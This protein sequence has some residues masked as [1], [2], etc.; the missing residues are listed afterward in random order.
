MSANRWLRVEQIFNAALSH[1]P[2]ARR[3]ILDTECGTDAELKA[4]VESL[5]A[6]DADAGM[7]FNWSAV[8]EATALAK[9][10]P[11]RFAPGDRIGP[12]QLI[13]ALGA[14]GMGAVFLAHDT[15]L[16]RRVALKLIAPEQARDARRVDRFRTEA[17][18]AAALNHPNVA[19]VH[20]VGEWDN[21][22]GIAME[23][24]EGET[25]D[26]RLAHG[27]FPAAEIVDVAT[28]AAAALDEAH[29]H[30]VIHRDVKP[31]NVMIT[32][33][34]LVK[35]LDFG[36]AKMGRGLDSALEAGHAPALATATGLVMGTAA[37]TS[38]EQVLGRIVDGRADIFSLGATL[39]KLATG[40][41]PFDGRTPLETLHAVVHSEP[42][43]ISE[44]NPAVPTSLQRV[45]GKCLQKR[46]EDR[47]QSARELFV[48][49]AALRLAGPS[50]R[51]WNRRVPIRVSVSA[52]A[53]IAAA[54]IAAVLLIQRGSRQ[55]AIDSIAVLPFANAT[56]GADTEYLSD[57]ISDGLI[58]RLSQ[59][60]NI[61]VTARTSS[62]RYKGRAV[63][64]RA[65]ARALSVRGIVTGSV[66]SLGDELS[67]SVELVDG[68]NNRRLWTRTYTRRPTDLLAL[69]EDIAQD[70]SLQFPPGTIRGEA[71][72]LRKRPTS[73]AEAY[74]LYLKGRYLWNKRT[75]ETHLRA[76]SYFERA[77]A[78]DPRFALAYAG[79][80]DTY[81]LIS[82]RSDR[83]RFTA[84]R[85][86][87][88]KAITL[89]DTLAEAYAALGLTLCLYDWDWPG[90]GRAFERALQ[91]NP[92]YASAHQW[93]GMYYQIAIGRFDNAIQEVL[94][95]ERLDPLSVVMPNAA[96][97]TFHLH[98]E[99]DRALEEYRK[100]L[101]IEPS[102]R[103]ILAWRARTYSEMRRYDDAIADY[104]KVLAASSNDSEA[105]ARLAA[106]HAIAGNR[107]KA[108][109]MFATAKR[110][111]R[112]ASIDLALMASALGHRD[113]AFRWLEKAFEDR[114]W[115]LI[116]LKVDSLFD[117]L[118]GDPRLDALVRRVGLP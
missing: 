50:P 17:L 11:L 38:P 87:A 74:E 5:L 22:N 96:G 93:S 46:P 51:S 7:F 107:A 117:P 69:A 73:N 39:Y 23:Y 14:G 24:V 72:G 92:N 111:D 37:Y 45:I 78:A 47:Y 32:P 97:A 100:G 43:P 33:K 49:L 108:E 101:E 18:A 112:T 53:V 42:K 81:N 26:A 61:K 10:L 34:G 60:L 99:Y 62:F 110:E 30:G 41:L 84:A 113:E 16:Q 56:G 12:F 115:K 77:I 44:L 114:S 106:T 66:R 63:D 83:E 86:A 57:G 82:D 85:T 6:A 4:D 68:G 20:E 1:D 64:P 76:L 40:R 70:V 65:A 67:I 9:A 8:E 35:I 55:D 3:R 52:S 29:S 48:D 59:A 95:A 104:Q 25:L 116:W 2:A 31:S 27:P 98:R 28:Q 36:V 54:L 89:D 21:V 91:L 94:L 109:S 71:A 15:R 19:T 90:A 105:F 13:A 103:N 80:A 102:F 75:T 88:V 118:R 58:N 79:L